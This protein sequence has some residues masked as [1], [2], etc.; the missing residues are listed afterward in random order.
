MKFIAKILI[1][2][3][4]CGVVVSVHPSRG[5]KAHVAA[6]KEG[7]RFKFPGGRDAL[8]TI[9]A[10]QGRVRFLRHDQPFDSRV[11]DTLAYLESLS[12]ADGKALLRYDPTNEWI[13]IGLP[14]ESFR[15]YVAIVLPSGYKR[16]IIDRVKR[17]EDL[18]LHRDLIDIVPCSREKS[19]CELVTEILGRTDFA[20]AALVFHILPQL[21][22]AVIEGFVHNFLDMESPPPVENVIAVRAWL[23]RRGF[24]RLK[25]EMKL[26]RAIREH[27]SIKGVDPL[28][29][30]GLFTYLWNDILN[31]GVLVEKFHV[32]NGV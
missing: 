15:A 12:E 11:D 14:W 28:E 22:E 8:A 18:I 26:I 6:G 27:T 1:G 17:G 7:G 2:A 16:F 32:V 24:N 21:H 9:M 25:D 30:R 10:E 19:A 13:G 3:M 4:C 5:V 29:P 31:Q 23:K 20:M